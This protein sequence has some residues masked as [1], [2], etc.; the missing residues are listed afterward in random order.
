MVHQ[1]EPSVCIDLS[2]EGEP[3]VR[4]AAFAE[5]APGIVGD[6]ADNGRTD[7]GGTDHGVWRAAEG[8]D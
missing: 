4:R 2:K 3:S 1:L 7:G 8:M 5:C 6:A